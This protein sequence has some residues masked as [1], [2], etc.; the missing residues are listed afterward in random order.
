MEE[1]LGLMA[2]QRA[3]IAVNIHLLDSDNQ[4]HFRKKCVKVFVIISSYEKDVSVIWNCF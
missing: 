2:G 4:N 1:V 3:W